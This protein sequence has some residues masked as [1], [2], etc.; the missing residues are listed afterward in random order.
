MWI[1]IL[2]R[3]LH[4]RFL[5][6]ACIPWLQLRPQ[7]TTLV[8][9]SAIVIILYFESEHLNKITPIPGS[10]EEQ[11]GSLKKLKIDEENVYDSL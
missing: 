7:N 11:N 4:V 8:K 5:Q 1:I 2:R 10:H 6:T 3:L 9:Y